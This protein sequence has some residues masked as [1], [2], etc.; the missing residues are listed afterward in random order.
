[1]PPHKSTASKNQPTAPPH[2]LAQ[3]SQLSAP[4]IALPLNSPRLRSIPKPA[5]R[6]AIASSSPHWRRRNP[7]THGIKGL[8]YRCALN[9]SPGA[10]KPPPPEKRSPYLPTRLEKQST[11]RKSDRLTSPVIS[12]LQILFD[13]GNRVTTS[14]F[15]TSTFRAKYNIV[16]FKLAFVVNT[17]NCRSLYIHTVTS[18]HIL[19]IT[20]RH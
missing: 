14:C 7:P 11:V 13:I 9:P 10:A 16:V 5:T 2:K 18:G 3:T 12:K 4:A 15:V 19:T 1:M 6:K 17:P 8:V 20:V